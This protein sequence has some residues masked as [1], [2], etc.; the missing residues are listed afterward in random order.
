MATHNGKKAAVQTAAG[1]VTPRFRFAGLHKPGVLYTFEE[2]AGDEFG[3]LGDISIFVAGGHSTDS[4]VRV[5]V[6]NAV[7]I[8]A[9]LEFT[10]TNALAA[11]CDLELIVTEPLTIT[12]DVSILVMWPATSNSGGSTGETNNPALEFLG[13]GL[14]F[15]FTFQ[16]QS[17]GAQISTVTSSDHAHI[18]ESIRQILGTKK[19]ERFMRPD[20]GTRLHELVFETSDQL[21]YGLIRHDVIEALD[22]WEPRIIV[23]DVTV[24]AD[25]SDEHLV[26]VN[27]SYRLISSQVEGNMVIPFWRELE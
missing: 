8:D 26:I 1:A 14:K 20:F 24:A 13:K 2:A 16:R 21:L 11:L 23:T 25:G 6:T 22:A 12:A 5:D 18:H 10:I 27:I 7:V 15:P 9:D 17:G 3:V 4:D 19:G